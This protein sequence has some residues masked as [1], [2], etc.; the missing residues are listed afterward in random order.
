MIAG[1]LDAF[2]PL[3]RLVTISQHNLFGSLVV[4]AFVR[5]VVVV[6][7][8]KGRIKRGGAPL[9]GD[10]KD[11]FLHLEHQ[12]V[13]QLFG[14]RLDFF[15]VGLGQPGDEH[16]FVVSK[17][18]GNGC[19]WTVTFLRKCHARQSATRLAFGR[20]FSKESNLGGCQILEFFFFFFFF[21]VIINYFNFGN[22]LL[23]LLVGR[24]RRPCSSRL[25][26]CCTGGHTIL[27]PRWFLLR[28][29]LVV[30]WGHST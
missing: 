20:F 10:A 25:F 11:F 8:I 29:R 14:H 17:F 12:F 22:I 5:W 13:F 26:Q 4:V 23:G 3:I 24:R 30:F 21:V 9:D 6:F 2:A 7:V 15:F 18:V 27:D 28:F 1:C 16:Q 19:Q